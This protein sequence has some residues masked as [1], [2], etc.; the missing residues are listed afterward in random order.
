MKESLALR[1][2]YHTVPGRG[3]LR[4]LIHPRLSNLAGHFLDT[5]LSRPLVGPFMRQNEITLDGIRIPE[6]GFASFNDFFSRTREEISFDPLPEHL[7]SP[8]DGFLSCFPISPEGR[9]SI[10]HSEYSVAGLLN[11]PALAARFHG[12]LALVLRLTPANYHRYHFVDD[13]KIL[14]WKKIPG[15]LHCVRPIAMERFPVFIQNSREYTLI[16]SDHFGPMVQMEIGALLVG[17]IINHDCPEQISR[18]QEK[19][20]FAFGGST[21][22][23]LLSPGRAVISDSILKS[24]ES[25]AEEPVTVGQMLGT[26]IPSGVSPV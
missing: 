10:K 6:G 20:Y 2:L 13:G 11:D 1:F 22:V 16:E 23:L 3:I 7:C 21:I 17:K 25:Q 15:V 24:L 9:F 4:L 19:G 8:C 5:S 14:A 12:G 18:G 26:A